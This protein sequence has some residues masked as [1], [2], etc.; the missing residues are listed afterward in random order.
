MSHVTLSKTNCPN[1]SK[2]YTLRLC[3]WG[4]I[5]KDK[6]LI[7][8]IVIHWLNFHLWQAAHCTLHTSMCTLR[9]VPTS[10][11]STETTSEHFILH[12]EHFALHV[13]HLY[14]ML[15]IYHFSLKRKKKNCLSDTHDLHNKMKLNSYDTYYCPQW[16]RERGFELSELCHSPFKTSLHLDTDPW[17]MTHDTLH[18]TGVWWEE[19]NLLSNCQLPSSLVTSDMWHLT[20][21]MWHVSHEMCVITHRGWWSLGHNLKSLEI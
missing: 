8:V 17:H 18:V 12:I 13:I 10:A 11:N 16:T 9:T 20:H 5:L 7:L 1:P 4:A 19:M 14:C 6:I 21:D 2:N 3:Y 15:H